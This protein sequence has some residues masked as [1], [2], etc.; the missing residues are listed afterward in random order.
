MYKND[1]NNLLSVYMDEVSKC[2]LL[3]PKEE[4]E[5]SGT[6]KKN[7]SILLDMILQSEQGID[8]YKF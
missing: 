8:E 3:T 7:K 4:I 2:P 5:Y 6:I 1:A